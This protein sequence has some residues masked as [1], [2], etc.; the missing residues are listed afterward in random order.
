MGHSQVINETVAS[1]ERRWKILITWLVS[2][3][4]NTDQPA[5]GP[6]MREGAGRGLFATR[7][8][9][10][11]S[12][13]FLRV[14]E[15]ALLNARTLREIYPTVALEGFSASKPPGGLVVN[16]T[17][18]LSI[19]LALNRP[20]GDDE[21]KDPCFGPYISILPRDF[22]SHPLSWIIKRELGQAAHCEQY[23]LQYLPPDVL[24]ELQA[25]AKR[26]WN[27]WKVALRC[28]ETYQ[29][30]FCMDG[31]P[32]VLDIDDFLWAWLI[33]NTRCLYSKIFKKNLPLSNLTL[34]PIIDFA[35][36]AT[37]DFLPQVSPRK[38]SED[39]LAKPRDFVFL[40]PG[41]AV[42]E[43]EEVYLKYGSH[44]NRTLFAEYGFV[45]ECSEPSGGEVEVSD[46]V[47]ELA[48]S[49]SVSNLL[50]EQGYLSDV[51][52]YASPAPV[53]PSWRLLCALRLANLTF[54][55]CSSSA[56]DENTMQSW[57]DVT[58]GIT[59]I[60]SEDNEVAVREDLG[61]ICDMLLARSAKALALLRDDEQERENSLD[62]Y[63]WAKGNIVKLWEEEK[64]VAQALADAL[65]TGRVF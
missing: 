54:P 39:A 65:A 40:T 43:G 46:L 64:R 57:R 21:S 18:L 22:G 50:D 12:V 24:S 16:G 30:V 4:F 55:V 7:A 3:G 19:H 28:A 52:V 51:S 42:D 2:K 13:P 6:Q 1:E 31:R 14:P 62:W 32:K 48:L 5:V 45:G 59:D 20:T 25:V 11:P 41:R 53:H 9:P 10:S 35:N 36:H 56:E 17:Q 33:V 29:T 47:N 23:L 37:S 26:F 58:T 44:C 63:E 15:A 49:K 8:L 60:V 61:W 38:T 27:D 34:C